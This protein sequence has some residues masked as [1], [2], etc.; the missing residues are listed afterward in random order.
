MLLL[1][2]AIT[3]ILITCRNRQFIIILFWGMYVSLMLLVN[4]FYCNGEIQSQKLIQPLVQML[5]N[6]VPPHKVV[7]LI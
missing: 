7:L 2:F 1:T 3:A 4:S 6:K 5:R